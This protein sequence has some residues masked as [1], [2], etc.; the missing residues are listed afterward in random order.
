MKMQKER[1]DPH[2]LEE[3]MYTASSWADFG[4]LGVGREYISFTNQFCYLGTII[5]SDFSD[6]ADISCLIKQAS[7]PF[8]SLSVGVFCNWKH[9]SPKVCHCLFMA[10][11]ISLLLQGCEMWALS[12]HHRQHLEESSCFNKWI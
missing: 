4:L 10:I 12:K 9:L 11:V 5:S 6:N 2:S 3:Y 8:G 7:K 1:N